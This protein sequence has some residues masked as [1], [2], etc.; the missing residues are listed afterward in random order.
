MAQLG[1]TYDPKRC[2]GCKA[3]EVACKAENNTRPNRV[4]QLGRPEVNYREVVFQ[5][6]S[7]ANMGT[8]G[9]AG[10]R[11]L[12]VS[13]NH[14]TNPKCRSVCPAGAISK[15]TANGIVVIT[16]SKCIGCRKCV[17]ACPYGAPRYNGATRRTEKCTLCNHRLTGGSDGTAYTADPACIQTCVG[18][19]LRINSAVSWSSADMDGTATVSGA[20]GTP[21][22]VALGVPESN[23]TARRKPTTTANYPLLGLGRVMPR[24]KLQGVD[25]TADSGALPNTGWID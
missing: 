15:S 5:R 14:C 13:C 10:R 8:T 18:K 3:C 11:F 1:F 12:S 22:D 24:R 25:G 4:N 2:R 16:Q 21:T 7:L 9:Y 23:R 6:D 19:A 20:I 17:F